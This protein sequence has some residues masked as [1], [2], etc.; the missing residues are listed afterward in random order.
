MSAASDSLTVAPSVAARIFGL[1]SVFGKALHES[2][3]AVAIAGLLV[4]GLTFVVAATLGLQFPEQADRQALVSQMEALPAMFRGLLG[5]PINID[6]L[7]GFISWRSL[8]FM[9]ILVGI[10]SAIAMSGAV[11]GEVG[12]G[13]MEVLAAS[14]VSRPS[15]ALQKAAAH[16]V[17]LLAAMAIA[18]LLTWLATVVFASFA[19]DAATLGA[20][21]AEFTWIAAGSLFAGAI[22]FMLGPLLGRA[23]AA[24]TGAVTLI[25]MYIVN[26]F[27]ET[28]TFFDRVSV[29]S[30]FDWTA[31]HRPLAGVEDWGP[32][33]GIAVIDAVLI[34]CGVVLFVRR[35]IGS[36][37]GSGFSPF[38]ADWSVANPVTRSL[39]ERLPAA[40]SFGIGIGAFG[41]YMA[42]SAES[43][44]E[45]IAD[46]PQMQQI[47]EAIFPDID[48]TSA[49][50]I[51][52]LMFV[53]FAILLLGLAAV[54]LAH[55]WASDERDGRLEMVL[56]APIERLRWVI[57][58]GAG[59]LLA[60]LALTVAVALLIAL[61]AAAV[62]DDVVGPVNGV[63]ALGLYASALVGIGVGVGGWFGPA[64]AGVVLGA[65]VVGVYVLEFVGTALELPGWMLD[66][67]LSRHL[68]D[69]FLGAAD[70]IGLL[71]CAAFA[72]SGVM[73]GAYGLVRRDLKG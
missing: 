26:G 45:M 39:A 33:L 8:N 58:S 46:I 18:A 64:L 20:S 40:L 29:L 55:G 60:M 67:A 56:G 41:F 27:S 30:I 4:G 62:G 68:G 51:L 28:V 16:V 2:R 65:Y 43:F 35:D 19:G 36:V 53:Q 57:G 42:V 73:A 12:K 15:I 1:G 25:A 59:V 71:L 38:A 63:F 10:W 7:S 32:V 24:A 54:V 72:A 21:L 3:V 50:G 69:P 66:V 9:P 11:A 6:T 31:G 44:A 47:L 13:S 17:A 34:G 14:V 23:A 61:G 49:S 5:E 37:V 70:P 22:A 48:P 52:G